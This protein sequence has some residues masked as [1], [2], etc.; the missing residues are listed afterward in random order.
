MRTT[1]AQISLRIASV[2]AQTGLSLPWS[3]TPEDTFC[4]VVAHIFFERRDLR[5]GSHRLGYT[6]DKMNANLEHVSQREIR[7]TTYT[8]T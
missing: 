4:R 5:L 7:W 2:A 1:K 8:E 3:E 6:T